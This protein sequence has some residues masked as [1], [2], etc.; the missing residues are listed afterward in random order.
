MPSILLAGSKEE[1]AEPSAG[2]QIEMGGIAL[3]FQCEPLPQISQEVL[4][5]SGLLGY[6]SA[7]EANI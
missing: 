3:K 1:Q 6:S 7:H 5:T 4:T 2:D